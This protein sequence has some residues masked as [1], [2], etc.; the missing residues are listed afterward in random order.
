MKKFSNRKY[1]IWIM[2]KAHPPLLITSD[3]PIN[4]VANDAM[5]RAHRFL[6]SVRQENN[7]PKT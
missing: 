5:S 1:E 6:H 7:H 4:Q 3:R 2:S